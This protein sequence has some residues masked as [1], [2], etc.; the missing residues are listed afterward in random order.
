MHQHVQGEDNSIKTYRK[1]MADVT[2]AEKELQQTN[3]R[4]DFRAH[5]IDAREVN[6]IHTNR[7]MLTNIL[8]LDGK[9]QHAY[10][11][12][13]EENCILTIR[14]MLTVSLLAQAN[15]HHAHFRKA[16]ETHSMHT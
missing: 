4:N 1:M 15:R 12:K 7:K 5:A 10:I 14:E 8:H 9:V 3:V 2:L 16:I 6:S 13:R 11:V